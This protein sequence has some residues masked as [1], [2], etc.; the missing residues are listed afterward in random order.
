MPSPVDVEIV[1]WLPALPK[2][3]LAKTSKIDVPDEEA[4]KIKGSVVLAVFPTTTNWALA[5]MEAVVVVPMV[6]PEVVAVSS[7]CKTVWLEGFCIKIAI[8]ELAM[9][10]ICI[11]PLLNIWKTDWLLDEAI[12]NNPIVP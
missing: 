9:E 2:W 11:L 8:L 6:K 5:Y 12:F 4:V 1:G 3:L 10:F 7:T